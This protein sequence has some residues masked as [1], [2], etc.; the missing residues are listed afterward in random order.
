M[1]NI[2]S[3]I[4]IYNIY[5]LIATASEQLPKHLSVHSSIFPVDPKLSQSVC[6]LKCAT[7]WVGRTRDMIETISDQ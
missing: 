5:Y 7:L 2:N 4:N 3:L 1:L 6:T